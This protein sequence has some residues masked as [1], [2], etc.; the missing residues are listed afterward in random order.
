MHIDEL[1]I[2]CEV[3]E[4][5]LDFKDYLVRI[6][7]SNS[8]SAK[9]IIVY[10]PKKIAGNN[11]I[12]AIYEHKKQDVLITAISNSEECPII[13]IEYSTAAPTDDH[14]MQR[15]DVVFWG[16]VYG[17]PVMKISPDNKRMGPNKAHGGGNKITSD[18]E[19]YIGVANKA[20]FYPIRWR[21]DGDKDIL[22][23]NETRFSCVPFNNNIEDVLSRQLRAYADSS[24]PADY[25]RISNSIF[26][27]AN[28]KL[29]DEINLSKIKSIFPN[30]NRIRWE[31]DSI[32]VKINRFG[33][34]MDPERGMI[35]FMSLLLGPNE[36]TSEIQI[37]RERIQ[38]K[39]G[40]ESLFDGISRK[41][42]L[43]NEVASLIDNNIKMTPEVA[44]RLFLKSSNLDKRFTKNEWQSTNEVKINDDELKS[45]LALSGKESHKFIFTQS[46]RLILT[47]V[48]RETL[49]E[50][51]WDKKIA[52]D[53]L[54]DSVCNDYTPTKLRKITASDAGEDIITFACVE[55]MRLAGLNLLSVSYPG[56]QGDVCVLIGEGRKVERRYVDI[57]AYVESQQGEIELFL[58][59]NKD[60]LAKSKADVTKLNI[61]RSENKEELL[62]LVRKRI[63]RNGI[64]SITIGIGA[65]KPKKM[66]SFDVDY[67]MTF[68]LRLLPENIIEWAIWSFDQK[69]FSTF[70]AAKNTEGKLK[71]II[72]IDGIYCV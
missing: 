35:Y 26:K 42:E 71:G 22:R 65:K 15:S 18:L 58:Q 72:N 30:S 52:N 32:I 20:P 59:E 49:V 67:I 40:Y 62:D 14:I 54:K 1:R 12:S 36:V 25:I 7:E 24:T 27:Q 47:N 34:A 19:M 61:L 57:I 8:I 37:E 33:H 70:N 16:A 4:Q 45:Y 66:E 53:Y 68:D 11:I 28:Q 51:K 17:V 13:A 10:A 55:V 38:G 41:L 44:F 60:E 21:T 56:A 5:A 3:Y 43:L 23:L 64:N 9:I 69:V 46:S 31:K 63:Q 50:I 6:M 29:C 48:D 39:Q 2:Y